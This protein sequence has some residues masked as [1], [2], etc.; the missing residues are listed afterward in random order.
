M[1]VPSLNVTRSALSTK[2]HVPWPCNFGHAHVSVELSGA[3]TLIRRC[4]CMC[5]HNNNNNNKNTRP[6]CT[7]ECPSQMSTQ[8]HCCTDERALF[9]WHAQANKQTW[10]NESIHYRRGDCQWWTH[11]LTSIFHS[12][13]SFH[14]PLLHPC[15]PR[16]G[17]GSFHSNHP[18]IGGRGFSAEAGRERWSALDKP[19]SSPS[20]SLC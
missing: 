9:F 1:S 18:R 15:L 11:G 10:K 8:I 5:N 12:P 20:L 13:P 16:W 14:I 19:P 2:Q 3:G 17:W 4:G 7:S 6:V